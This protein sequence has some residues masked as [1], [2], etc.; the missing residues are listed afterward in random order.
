MHGMVQKIAKI[1]SI[2]QS[3]VVFRTSLS[4]STC[5]VYKKKKIII[6]LSDSE[7]GGYLLH[8]SYAP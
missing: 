2:C 6:H 7:G 1:P 4:Y 5:V 8:K 3:K